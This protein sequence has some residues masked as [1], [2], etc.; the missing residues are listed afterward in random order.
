V[1]F[2]GRVLG[3]YDDASVETTKATLK[4]LD[5]YGVDYRIWATPRCAVARTTAAWAT[6]CSSR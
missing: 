5:H 3:L 6:S 1:L 2:L 4:V